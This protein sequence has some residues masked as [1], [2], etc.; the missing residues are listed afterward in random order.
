M[1][2]LGFNYRITD[3]QCA[4]GSS[5]LKKLDKFIQR[6]KEVAAFYDN[7]FSN[8]E[9]FIIPK[10]SNEVSHSYHL[11]PLQIN[12]DSLKISKKE[13][14]LSLRQKEILC[15]VHYIPVHFQPY[16]QKNFGFKPGDF[17]VVEKFYEREISI[18]VFYG[19]NDQDLDFF[20]TTLKSLLI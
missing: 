7:C 18:P 15:Q 17:P 3:F 13:L 14:F 2:C 10:V 5:Q 4:L 6:R 20:S 19:L 16:Y 12:F 9:R 11:Y 8:D 1:Q